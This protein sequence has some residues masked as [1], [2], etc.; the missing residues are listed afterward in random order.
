MVDISIAI[1]TYNGEARLGKVLERLRSQQHTESIAWE[2]VVVDNNSADRTKA[3]IE[4]YQQHWNAP[5]S[6]RYV[7]EA[8]QGLA[9]ARSRAI[10]EAAGALVSFLDDDT[11][12]AKDW[13][14]QAYSFAQA[15]AHVGAFGGQVHGDYEV[16]P[17]PGFEKIAVFLAIIERG[18]KPFCY[19]PEAKILPPGAGLVVRRQ[20]WLDHVP[21]RTVLLGRVG[22]VM[23]ASEDIE[24]LAYI[25]KAGWEIWYNPNLHLYHQIPQW[26]MERTYLFSL[27]R[28]IGFARTQVR[29]ARLC[30]WQRPF[31][32]PIYLLN[33]FKRVVLHVIK[34]RKL[35]R[36]DLA[37]ACEMQWL[38]SSL[39]SP[40]Y[41]WLHMRR[42][43]NQ[44]L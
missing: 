32:L 26:R 23:L 15:H 43:S 28:G 7:F 18:S 30:L 34:H 39:L 4:G 8:E 29:M 37:V 36:T 42:R 40:F 41:M 2:I 20:V 14:A 10:R 1:C 25:Q 13:V 16:E 38:V 31:W 24:A 11:L 12:P 6:L 9:L 5:F 21:A 22:G 33:D 19:K 35:I 27:I 3:L 17:P 44:I